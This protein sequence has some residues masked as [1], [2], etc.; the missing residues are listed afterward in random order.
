MIAACWPTRPIPAKLRSE[1]IFHTPHFT[2]IR[3][4]V[5][6]RDGSDHALLYAV[7]KIG[8]Q[9]DAREASARSVLK[10]K[11]TPRDPGPPSLQG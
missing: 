5:L 3:A 6:R 2:T 11:S 9:S 7:L 4:E 10:S 8:E 1:Y